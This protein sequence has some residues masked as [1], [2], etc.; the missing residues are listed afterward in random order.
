[1][2]AQAAVFPLGPVAWTTLVAR[3]LVMSGVACCVCSVDVPPF[4]RGSPTAAVFSAA[5]GLHAHSQCPN[6]ID[7]AQLLVDACQKAEHRPRFDDR[8]YP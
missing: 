1:M 4:A 6:Q 3:P 7:S 5:G 2:L 8:R